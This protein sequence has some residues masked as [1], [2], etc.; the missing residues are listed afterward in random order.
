VSPA[1]NDSPSNG[2]Q[3]DTVRINGGPD[4][5]EIDSFRA[6]KMISEKDFH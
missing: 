2:E 3:D 6:E 1:V 5:R 4:Y